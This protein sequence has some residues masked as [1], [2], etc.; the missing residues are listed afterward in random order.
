MQITQEKRGE[1]T[2]IINSLLPKLNETTGKY[3][4]EVDLN[5]LLELQID[6][7]KIDTSRTYSRSSRVR[8]AAKQ[9]TFTEYRI[10]VPG[11]EVVVKPSL[12]NFEQIVTKSETTLVPVTF[13]QQSL[14]SMNINPDETVKVF[15][16]G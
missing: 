14:S 4:L 10:I 8:K 12:S 9:R 7:K 5:G 3:L 16:Q 6:L 11:Q 1:D 15:Q 13:P 2:Y